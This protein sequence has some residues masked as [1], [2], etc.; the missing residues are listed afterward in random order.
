MVV[1]GNMLLLG[2][3][4]GVVVLGEGHGGLQA[5]CG[6]AA[7]GLAA[8]SQLQLPSSLQE[9]GGLAD[10]ALARGA[11]GEVAWRDE[12]EKWARL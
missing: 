4:D 1:V 3:G 6:R 5:I 8:D 12:G 9:G 7:A 2:A 11:T 10:V